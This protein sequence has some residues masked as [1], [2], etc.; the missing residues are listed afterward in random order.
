MRHSSGHT[1]A[2]AAQRAIA[3][4]GATL[5]ARSVEQ[6]RGSRQAAGRRETGA[7]A[8]GAAASTLAV[9]DTTAAVSA[10]VL[11]V[12]AD[13]AQAP[14]FASAREQRLGRTHPGVHVVPGV[15]RRRRFDGL[16]A[17][18]LGAG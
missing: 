7:G 10:P 11:I 4:A 6:D 9:T 12:A 17:I 18:G 14:A 13:D 3:A 5:A 8:P 1:A 2:F 15:H 16:E